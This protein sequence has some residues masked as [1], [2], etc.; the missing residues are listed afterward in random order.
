MYK[1]IIFDM[2]R[3]LVNFDFSRGYQALQPFSPYSVAEIPKRL[4]TT[5]LA[6]DFE[7]GLIE[8]HDFLARMSDLLGFS[9]DYDQFC[10][11]WCSIFAETLVPESLLETLAARY[12]LVLLSNTN[13]IHFAMICK[14]YP[15]MRHFHELVLSYEVKA[16][17]PRHEIFERAIERAGCLP[18]ECFYTDDI[19]EYIEAARKLGIDGVQFRG[20][21]QLQKDLK[22]RGIL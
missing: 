21:E 20:I 9:M 14:T 12:R 4:A 5:S 16:M 10:S 3:V 7:T 6:E 22:E 19:A 13:A 11:I 18:G 1:A 15:M 8:P 2:G 17:K